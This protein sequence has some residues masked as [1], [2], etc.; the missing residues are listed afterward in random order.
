[1]TP[2]EQKKSYEARKQLQNMTRSE[3]EQLTTLELAKLLYW[4][5]KDVYDELAKL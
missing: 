5:E 3:R 2:E 4:S 1:M